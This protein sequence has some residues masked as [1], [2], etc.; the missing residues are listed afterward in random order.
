MTKIQTRAQG[1]NEQTH[2]HLITIPFCY[3]TLH[4]ENGKAAK[5]FVEQFSFHNIAVAEA[6][7]DELENFV[8]VDIERVSRLVFANR[9][10]AK[11]INDVSKELAGAA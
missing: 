10:F 7:V 6:L 3:G 5:L 1:S 8:H 11:A 4:F 9:D 2:S